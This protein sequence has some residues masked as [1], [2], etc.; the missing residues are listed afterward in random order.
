M[1]SS[2]DATQPMDAEGKYPNLFSG[3]NF[4]EPSLRSTAENKYLP[5]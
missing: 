2:S 1:K 4:V 5:L 3:P